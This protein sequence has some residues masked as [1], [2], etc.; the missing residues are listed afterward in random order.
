MGLAQNLAVIAKVESVIYAMAMVSLVKVTLTIL[1]WFL[2][3]VREKLPAVTVMA[4]ADVYMSVTY[5]VV[6]DIMMIERIS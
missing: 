6:Q 5:A 3:V 2:A 4:R 1:L